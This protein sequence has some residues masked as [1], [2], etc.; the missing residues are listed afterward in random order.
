[1][2][3]ETDSKQSGGDS[4]LPPPSAPATLTVADDGASSGTGEVEVGGYLDV[5]LESE[6]L[7]P[8]QKAAH[9]ADTLPMDAPNNPKESGGG[10][11]KQAAAT[12]A[13]T[14]SVASRYRRRASALWTAFKA[15]ASTK[16]RPILLKHHEPLNADSSP[17][18]RAKHAL[19]CPPHGRL[20]VA[21]TTVILALT[22]WGATFLLLGSVAAPP[23]G[24]IFWIMVIVVFAVL[25]GKLVSLARLPP[26]LGMLVAGLVVKNIPGVGF[27]S[28]W[29]GISSALRGLAL[30]VIL[31]R[32]GL[33]LDPKALKRLSGMVFR[34]AFT[35]CLVETT[36]V[37]IA[38][39]F[40]LGIPW[41]WGFMLGF[42]LAAV[43]PAVVVP[44]LLALSEKGYGVAKGIPTLVIAAASVDDVLA[45]SGFTILLGIAF[46]DQA[47]EVS[48]AARVFQGPKEAVV[49]LLFGIGWGLLC[50]FV[51]HKDSGSLAPLRWAMLFLGGIL[52]LFGSSAIGYKGSGA[53]AVLVMAFVA[54]IG[55]KSTGW[56]ESNPV[57]DYL[58]NM[59]LVFQP[60]LFALIGT[61]IRVSE[62]DASTV[63]L[64]ILVLAIGMTLRIITTF[65]VVMGG[66]LSLKERFFVA[67]A[68]LPKAT[69]QAAI[70][71]LALDQ[72]G[73]LGLDDPNREEY[74]QLGLVVLTVAVLAILIT[75]P[76]GSATIMLT[77]PCLLTKDGDTD[78]DENN[79]NQDA[80]H[81]A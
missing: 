24:S 36:V 74:K 61:E 76:I 46:Q 64:G 25:L 42:V 34:L 75:A 6:N 21:L 37:A 78:E 51:P 11:Q 26:L 40:L 27:D 48:T 23:N 15:D 70:G 72:A 29:A 71:P 54:G 18:H 3:V 59:W 53:L 67:L 17:L 20:S 39:H 73:K 44:C 55:W 77:H 8:D 65:F 33:G 28:H 47:E 7:D 30:I 43:S 35:P 45:I 38:S 9:E 32:A 10:G 19:L 5:S 58:Q 63:G 41:L 13:A 12:T 4:S 52:G 68:W 22:L 69:V 1:M 56:R 16:A 14:S 66:D 79:K 60:I 49:G 62:L 50:T 2:T 57:S 80:H 81:H 31:M